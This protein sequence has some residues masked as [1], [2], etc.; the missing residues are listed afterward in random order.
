MQDDLVEAERL[1]GEALAVAEDDESELHGIVVP[2]P[3]PI[4]S[5]SLR[6]WVKLT[7]GRFVAAADE[8]RDALAHAEEMD[9]EFFVVSE[10]C[11]I[12]LVA[13]FSG[14]ATRA[15]DVASAVE[16]SEALGAVRQVM[17]SRTAAAVV[18]AETGDWQR[19]MRS[20]DA[21]CHELTDSGNHADLRVPLLAAVV[22]LQRAAQPELAASKAR[23]MRT[24]AD[25]K[26]THRCSAVVC[27]WLVGGEE[28]TGRLAWGAIP[29][30]VRRNWLSVLAVEA[31]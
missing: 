20:L 8:F 30:E 15:S 2:N 4:T 12:A 11:H 19:A 13:A 7:Q 24:H 23:E 22:V 17:Q 10:L 25:A 28:P 27:E 26:L 16:R 21:I 14:Q 31:S 9:S 29:N 5:R 1:A 3:T 6:G 18:A